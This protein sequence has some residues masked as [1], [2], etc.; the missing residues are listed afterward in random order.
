MR[1]R[2]FQ[3][4]QRAQPGD[5][6]SRAYDIFLVIVS[7]ISII[8]MLFHADHLSAGSQA[9]INVLEL[10]AVYI[11]AFDYL[12]R[13][14]THDLTEGKPLNWKSFVRYPFTLTAIIDLLAIL[15]SL[16]VL[17]A[18][19]M[20]L[21]VLRVFRI[22]RY[23]RH[24]SIIANVFYQERK[25]LSLILLIAVIYIFVTSLIVFSLEGETFDSFI[26]ALYWGTVTLTTIGFG[27]VYPLTDAGRIITSISSLF[28]VFVLA[29]PAGIMTGSF[30]QQLQQREENGEKY[31]SGTFV[32]DF[33]W[34]NVLLTPIKTNEFLAENPKARV[35]LLTIV[36]GAAFDILLYSLAVPCLGLPVWLDT[37]GTAIV[38]C[39]ID[40]AAGIITGYV[41]NLFL[42][43]YTGSAGNLLY[44]AQSAVVALTYGILLSHNKRKKLTRARIAKALLIVIGV[45]TV[46]S[47]ALFIF[48][49]KEAMD[50][51]TMQGYYDMLASFGLP[52]YLAVF[53]SL[54]LDRIFDSIAV[55]FVVA[56]VGGILKN[57]K[58]NPR[59]WLERQGDTFEEDFSPY[60]RAKTGAAAF[61]DACAAAPGDAASGTAPGGTALG[62]AAP[63]DAASGAAAPG[64]TVSTAAPGEAVPDGASDVSLKAR[65]EKDASMLEAL[66]K[67]CAQPEEAQRY[68]DGARALRILQNGE[69][70]SEQEYARLFDALTFGKISSH[71]QLH[72]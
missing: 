71:E 10:I 4:V 20:F 41:N 21:R 25:T 28:G 2:I 24:L 66:A 32:G 57:P 29:L 45:Q 52:H 70:R 38:A 68:L 69:V 40:P 6:V 39:A 17:P 35:Y 44:L 11:L 31:F 67:N 9:F 19:F 53:A 62:A 36:A 22:F 42:A 26:E 8:P 72:E 30:L 49:Q 65:I 12:L 58:Y 48:L 50:T 16:N 15:P 7:F 14:I 37:A 23:S 3:I 18:S 1:I 63:G 64:A 61:E 27:D 33:N 51:T 60:E 5:R 47:F 59:L 43:I 56:A 55:L 13:W 46:I 34:K 54:L